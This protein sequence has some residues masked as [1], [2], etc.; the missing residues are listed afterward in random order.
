MANAYTDEDKKRFMVLAGVGLFLFAAWATG[1]LRYI[2]RTLFES[3]TEEPVCIETQYLSRWGFEEDSKPLIKKGF[4]VVD[5]WG[6]ERS[7]ERK[8]PCDKYGNPAPPN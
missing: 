8:V 7:L 3:N 2:D 4:K 5:N 6:R 1:F